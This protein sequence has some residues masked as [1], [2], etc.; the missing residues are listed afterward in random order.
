MKTT[1]AVDE[2]LSLPKAA[3]L[4]DVTRHMVLNLVA[5]RE[6]ESR[7]VAERTVITRASIEAYLAKQ[8]RPMG[9]T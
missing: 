2:F 8:Q 3:S 4:L 7:T 6:L 5:K 1:K 9:A